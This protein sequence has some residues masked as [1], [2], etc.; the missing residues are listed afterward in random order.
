MRVW[1]RRV[2][3]QLEHVP[4]SGEVVEWKGRAPA[5]GT[6]QSGI[7]KPAYDVK[8]TSG[9]KLDYRAPQIPAGQSQEVRPEGCP[10]RTRP[11]RF[12]EVARLWLPQLEAQVFEAEK[13]LAELACKGNRNSAMIP[14][15][16]AHIKVLR[17]CTTSLRETLRE[18]R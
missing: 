9:A 13:V 5:Q 7:A 4:E 14:G 3:G 15:L 1:A 11:I 8:I 10:P 2:H 16:R 12:E 6:A 17:D 18:H